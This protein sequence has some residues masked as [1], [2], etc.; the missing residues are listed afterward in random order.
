MKIHHPSHGVRHFRRHQATF[1]RLASPSTTLVI[2]PRPTRPFHDRIYFPG[3]F[4]VHNEKEEF[5]QTVRL[6]QFFFVARFLML[7]KGR[8]AGS[9]AKRNENAG[10][11]W[12]H[13]S[14]TTLMKQ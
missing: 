10:L 12:R 2:E 1:S 7:W 14:T 5:M 11:V 8:E 4:L 9:R 3:C 6:G 13:S